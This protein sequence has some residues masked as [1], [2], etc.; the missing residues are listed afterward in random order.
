MSYSQYS[1]R[2]NY[3]RGVNNLIGEYDIPKEVKDKMKTHVL[4]ANIEGAKNMPQVY[5]LLSRQLIDGMSSKDCKLSD[6]TRRALS[7]AIG[8]KLWDDFSGINFA[9]DSLMPENYVQR[10][11]GESLMSN[12]GEKETAFMTLTNPDAFG[13]FLD[14]IPYNHGT[15]LAYFDFMLGKA[16]EEQII[17]SNRVRSIGDFNYVLD[18]L[19]AIFACSESLRVPRRRMDRVIERVKRK[20]KINERE[21]E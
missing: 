8:I 16:D 15:F 4:Y 5:Y 12:I 10:F 2:G 1:V 20:R 6:N 7:E 13:E 9:N 21:H 3:L 19:D 17:S 18:C 11:V 14:S